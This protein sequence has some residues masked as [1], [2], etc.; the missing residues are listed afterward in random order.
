MRLAHELA[1]E[2][3]DLQVT[4]VDVSLRPDLITRYGAQ[5]APFFVWNQ[6]AAFPG[7]LPELVL[8]Q[9]LQAEPESDR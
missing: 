3:R 9:R 8:L 7:P 4:A 1:L 6:Q 5:T 2:G